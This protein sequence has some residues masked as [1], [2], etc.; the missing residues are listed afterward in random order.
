MTCDQGEMG[1]PLSSNVHFVS[2]RSCIIDMKKM[3]KVQ[4]ILNAWSRESWNK[5][6][7]YSIIYQIKYKTLFQRLNHPSQI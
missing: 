1:S 3:F 2:E 5:Y 7:P 6:T 4:I